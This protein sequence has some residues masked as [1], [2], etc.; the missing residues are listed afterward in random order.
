MRR[1]TEY[2]GDAPEAV[3]QIVLA[4]Q[5]ALRGKLPAGA[6]TWELDS[7]AISADSSEAA[8]LGAAFCALTTAGTISCTCYVKPWSRNSDALQRSSIRVWYN[9]A[10]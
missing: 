4:Q 7:S 8:A 6:P 5:A 2:Q 1:D 10:D 9:K 3:K